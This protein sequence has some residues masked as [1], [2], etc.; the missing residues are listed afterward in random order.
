[1]CIRDRSY[2]YIPGIS[3]FSPFHGAAYAVVESL[4]KLAAVGADPLT[5]RLTFQE[6]FE[7][8]NTD[9]KRW[10]KPTAALLG[11]LSAQLGMGLP[12]IGGKD[13]MSGTFEQLDVPPTLVSFAVA[14]TK[15]SKTLSAG[16]KNPGATVVLLPLP[17]NPD[18]LLPDWEK[19]KAYYRA[20]R[21]MIQNGTVVSAGVVKE[22][23]A[24]AAV[25]KMCFGNKLGFA[26]EPG[27]CDAEFLFAP[28]S[29]AMVLE[30]ALGKEAAVDAAWSPLVL[31]KVTEDPSFCL[32][33]TSAAFRFAT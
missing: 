3:K 27:C 9:P 28:K 8:L 6:Y 21:N 5:A 14:M 10:G 30:L 1:M 4:S 17:E 16:M 2:G 11:A 15:A 22:G 12:A 24:G 19:L 7:R 25:A 13:S 33:Y 20:V 32:L 31:G 23:G 26:F 29:G 18:T